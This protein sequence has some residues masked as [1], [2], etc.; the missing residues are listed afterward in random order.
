MYENRAESIWWSETIL[1]IAPIDLQ[2]KPAVLVLRENAIPIVLLLDLAQLRQRA[3]S[4]VQVEDLLATRC[5]VHVSERVIQS[6]G[7]ARFVKSG[8]KVTS[9]FLHS[10]IICWG[11]PLDSDQGGWSIS[12]LATTQMQTGAGGLTEEGTIGRVKVNGV[13]ARIPGCL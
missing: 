5:I 3:S 11:R 8:D 4:A 12:Q 7:L 1:S 10:S 6:C 2:L 13:S 9:D